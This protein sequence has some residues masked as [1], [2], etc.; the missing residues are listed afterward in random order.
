MVEGVGNTSSGAA[1]QAAQAASEVDNSKPKENPHQTLIKRFFEGM[2]PDKDSYEAAEFTNIRRQFEDQ[3]KA[4]SKI[5]KEYPSRLTITIEN[6]TYHVYNFKDKAQHDKFDRGENMTFQTSFGDE[7][8]N[9]DKKGS[10]GSDLPVL[11]FY[12]LFNENFCKK[13]FTSRKNCLTENEQNKLQTNKFDV[14]QNDM[15]DIFLKMIA[16]REGRESNESEGPAPVNSTISPRSN[17]TAVIT[18]EASVN[19][20]VPSHMG[21]D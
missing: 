4:N 13:V 1:A 12:N 15:A 18:N 16:N 19:Q 17:A 3:V 14:H 6:K 8:I 10:G 21:P 11:T 20:A 9:S 7:I 5:I 2:E